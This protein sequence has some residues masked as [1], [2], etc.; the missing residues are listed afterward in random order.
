VSKDAI[1]ALK[2]VEKAVDMLET[3]AVEDN[4]PINDAEHVGL[5]VQDAR[6]GLKA[7]GEQHS[8]GVV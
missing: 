2:N 7:L 6:D 4:I 5:V 1:E 8:A 3:Y